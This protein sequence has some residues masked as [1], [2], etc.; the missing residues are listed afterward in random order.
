MT[1]CIPSA[2]VAEN[3]YTENKKN[4]KQKN[5]KQKDRK[6]KNKK[7]TEVQ[8]IPLDCEFAT[9]GDL[10]WA[11]KRYKRSCIVVKVSYNF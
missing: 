3:W 11:P 6:E 1:K 7:D 5:K 2:S 10:Y 8:R 9:K 4:K